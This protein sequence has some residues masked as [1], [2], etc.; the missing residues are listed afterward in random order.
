MRQIKKLLEHLK[1][2]TLLFA[3]REKLRYMKMNKQKAWWNTHEYRSKSFL[4][5]PEPKIQMKLHF[6]SDMARIIFCNDFE[7]QERKFINAFLKPGDIFVDVGA[8]I[9][10]F[11]LI[12]AK[13]VGS[14]GTV[15]AFE[16]TPKIYKELLENVILNGFQ[17]VHCIQKALSDSNDVRPLFVATDGFDDY[18]SFAKPITAASFVTEKV[19]CLTWDSFAVQEDLIGKVTMMK[20]D[21]EGW[22]SHVLQGGVSF[23]SRDDA[24]V[25]QVEFTDEASLAAGSS[26]RQLYCLLEKLGYK[27]FRYD[28]YRR[29]IISEPLRADY[30]YLN[31]IA[32]KKPED[33][34]ARIHSFWR[35]VFFKRKYIT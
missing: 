9:G 5:R 19:A 28:P 8:N 12:A 18:N 4:A 17:N 3:L 24:P 20:I 30:P 35:K 32:T 1:N 33:I 10:L 23:F 31:L 16:P 29:N 22:E 21:V 6:Q 2:R 11:A 27:M 7:W 25:L 34:Y 14:H 13:R 26:C 15:F